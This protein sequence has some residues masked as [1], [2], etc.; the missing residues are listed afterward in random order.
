[1][2]EPISMCYAIGCR[3]SIYAHQL[4]ATNNH[5]CSTEGC[6]NLVCSLHQ[7]CGDCELKKIKERLTNLE[8][9]VKNSQP[10]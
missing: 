3:N 4:T 10:S 8:K 2:S 5:R 7:I 9:I 1:M 6:T